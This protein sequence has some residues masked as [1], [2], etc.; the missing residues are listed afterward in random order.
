LRRYKNADSS[1]S[2]SFNQ[3]IRL[4][5]IQFEYTGS[6]LS[7]LK[8]IDLKIHKGSCVGF[9]G[10]SGSGKSTLVDIIMGLLLPTDGNL[11]VDNNVINDKNRNS[12]YSQIAHVPQTIFLSDAT[13][14]ENIAFG[15]PKDMIDQNRV[16]ESARKAQIIEMIEGLDQGYE[17]IVGEQGVKLSGGQRQRLGIAR[18]LYKGAKLLVLDEATSALDN[19]TERRV[20][21]AIYNLKEEMTVLIIAH[22]LST[23]KN[24]DRILELNNKNRVIERS[25]KEMIKEKQYEQ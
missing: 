5:K 19:E 21:N 24:C 12:W 1:N 23:L 4:N 9:I 7:I 11:V 8:S 17:T 10:A 13:I 22:R 3:E 25:Y 6:S 18:A 16:V 20:M 2:V 14:K 15:I